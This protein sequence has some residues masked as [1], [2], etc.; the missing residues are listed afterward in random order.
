MPTTLPLNGI[1]C[2]Y[3]CSRDLHAVHLIRASC[4]WFAVP[5]HTVLCYIC[6]FVCMFNV[7]AFVFHHRIIL[8][9]NRVAISSLYLAIANYIIMSKLVYRTGAVSVVECSVMSV[10]VCVGCLATKNQLSCCL[11]SMLSS[12]S[13]KMHAGLRLWLGIR[14]LYS[15]LSILYD[16]YN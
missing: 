15:P 16:L 11:S 10:C 12:V 7:N 14:S 2:L 5:P 13:M 8:S 4:M 6:M 9:C 1:I 3:V